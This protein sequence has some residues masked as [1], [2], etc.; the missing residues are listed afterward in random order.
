MNYTIFT[1]KL[2]NGNEIDADTSSQVPEGETIPK[3]SVV[4]EEAAEGDIP[5]YKFKINGIKAGDTDG[6][7]YEYFVQETGVPIDYSASYVNVNADYAVNE[8]TI[9]NTPIDAV[10]LPETGGIGTG[11]F[12]FAGIMLIALAAALYGLK[13]IRREPGD[14]K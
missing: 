12:R 5:T 2:V 9:V 8:G 1:N 4:L 13:T 6:N 7:S 14:E 3:L 10:D 11:I